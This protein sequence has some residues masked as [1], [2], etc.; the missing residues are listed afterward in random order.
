M[1][2]QL[3]SFNINRYSQSF[4]KA[5][6]KD[7]EKEQKPHSSHR[8]IS[9]ASKIALPL[10]L[11]TYYNVMPA[12]AATI[13]NATIP[14]TVNNLATSANLNADSYD[15]VVEGDCI[16]CETDISIKKE[17]GK[18]VGT[19]SGKVGENSFDLAYST[20]DENKK[21]ITGF[22]NGKDFELNKINEEINI[23]FDG[24]PLNI[25]AQTITTDEGSQIK[26][27]FEG[28]DF[29]I[30]ICPGE[31]D[32]EMIIDGLFDEKDLNLKISD[33]RISGEFDGKKID[34]EIDLSK[35]EQIYNKIKMGIL[36]LMALLA[37]AGIYN[38][39]RS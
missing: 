22:I 9:T 7:V 3:T 1:V 6:S 26:G 37:I 29:D 32:S 35:E 15:L 23:S 2:N 18:D 19:F 16:D 4:G 10:L 25:D 34:L 27:N 14:V 39:V 8:G 38:T 17:A 5:K 31:N 33:N 12:Q 30:K 13:P 20:K 21:N 24:K 36:G 28:K 11:A